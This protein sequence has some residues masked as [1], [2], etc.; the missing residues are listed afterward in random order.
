MAGR[1]KGTRLLTFN[2]YED[3]IDLIDQAARVAGLNKSSLMKSAAL[4]KARQIIAEHEELARR[5]KSARASSTDVP[6]R[7][8][9]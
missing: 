7:I 5:S 2:A 3:E 1:P 8:A 9:S 6:E 4:E